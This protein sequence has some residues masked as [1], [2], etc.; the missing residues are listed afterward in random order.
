M[1]ARI[2]RIAVIAIGCLAQI[3]LAHAADLKVYSTVGVKSALEELTPQ[4]E[5]LSGDKLAITWGTAVMLA[6]RIEA[7]E[8][9]DLLILTREALDGL[10][11]D[12]KVEPGTAVT[13]ASSGTV[14][15]VKSGA[16][17]PD[18]STPDAFKQTLLA[19]PAI[20]YVNP[21]SGGATG[22]YMAK[23]L[24]RMG[25]AEQMKP[26]TVYP[27]AGGNAAELVVADKAQLAIEPKP[28]AMAV[29]GIEVVG[30]LPGDLNSIA[31]FAAGISVGTSQMPA[32]RAALDG[33]RSP[34]AR[35]VYQAK[36]LDP[37]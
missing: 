18:I 34:E 2:G 28:E 21:A 5:K 14:V 17:K 13:F 26:K 32:A 30:M 15:A 31:Q 36:G 11:K 10:A 1:T 29:P 25:I 8:S 3:T 7:G 4:L 6:K 35:A 16:P 24:E 19:A 9:A 22:T 23:L 20:A 37:S 27:P 33:L 12:G